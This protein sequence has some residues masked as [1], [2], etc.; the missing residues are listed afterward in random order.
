[1]S[2]EVREAF[3]KAVQV[4]GAIGAQLSIVRGGESL[5]LVHG[6]A[7]AV[8][9]LPMTEDTLVQCGSVTKVLNAT[10]I[11]SLVEEGK[12]DLDVPLKEYIPEFMVADPKAANTISLRHLLTMSAGIDNGDYRDFGAGEDAIAKRVAS[13]RT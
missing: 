5:D 1:M 2:A 10:M 11:M 3:E 4:S 6:L 13:L 9:S 12:L 7:N 8:L